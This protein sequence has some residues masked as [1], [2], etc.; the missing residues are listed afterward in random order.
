MDE[1]MDI[2]GSVWKSERTNKSH[3][4]RLFFFGDYEFLSRV[5]GLI[6]S[7]GKYS[8]IY[9]LITQQGIKDGTGNCSKRTLDSYNDD[10]EEFVRNG[11]DPAKGKFVFHSV[12]RKPML[13]IELDKVSI[14]KE[15]I[16]IITGN[17]F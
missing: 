16:Y 4:L 7:N 9:C 15:K 2:E 1:V 13:N 14:Q 3:T 6:G 12:V 5:Y 17:S 11:S 8:C 10:F